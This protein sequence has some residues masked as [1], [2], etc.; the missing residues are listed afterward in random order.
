MLKSR[1]RND[2][3]GE[4]PLLS[5]QVALS[6]DAAVSGTDAQ[7]ELKPEA[8]SAAGIT[9]AAMNKRRRILR[10]VIKPGPFRWAY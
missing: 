9:A 5:K 3:P 8:A 10:V 2:C 1:S 7:C 4:L 6:V